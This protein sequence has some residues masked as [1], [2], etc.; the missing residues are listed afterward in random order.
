MYVVTKDNNIWLVLE[1]DAINQSL[2][3]TLVTLSKE[4]E[5]LF[6]RDIRTTIK[7]DEIM[8]STTDKNIVKETLSINNVQDEI[9]RFIDSEVLNEGYLEFTENDI[10]QSD[11]DNDTINDEI[12]ILDERYKLIS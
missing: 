11:F 5:I 12:G 6:D 1:N 10:H 4:G 8:F 3:I 9:E 7:T 2:E